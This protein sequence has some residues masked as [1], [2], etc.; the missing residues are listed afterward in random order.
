[1]VTNRDRKL[2]G[3][4]RKKIQILLRRLAKLTFLIRVQTFRDPLRAELLHIQIFINDGPNPLTW[5]VQLLSYWFS[6]NPAVFQDSFV[7]LISNLWGDHCFGSSGTRRIT[8]GKITTFKLGHPVFDGGIRWCVFPLC[9]SQNVV[10]FFRRLALQEKKKLDD[11]SRLDVV[12]IVRVAW[13]TSF[14]PL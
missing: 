3:S 12:E 8:G 10:N 5:D 11:S 4:R 2:F 1:M 9:F 6:R 14:Q 13:H 7:N